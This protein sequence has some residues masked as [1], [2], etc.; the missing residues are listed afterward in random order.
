MPPG[1][2]RTGDGTV[3]ERNIMERLIIVGAGALGRE[4]LGLARDCRAKKPAFE[5]GG[6]IDPNPNALDGFG[7]AV[8]IIGAECRPEPGD[9][10]VV[11]VGDP[12]IRAR[13]AADVADRGGRLISLIHP[14]AYMAPSATVGDG[15][16]VAAF[17]F[18]AEN[19]R[20]GR[21]VFLNTYASVGHDADIGE[22]AVFSPYAVV[23]G[24]TVVE[25]DA[26][27]G[28]HAVLAQGCRLGEGARL[29]AGSVSYRNVPPG[30]LALGNPARRRK[31]PTP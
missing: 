24:D 13:L 20:V 18:I 11:A 14:L 3:R 28:T 2:H 7:V 21:N 6:F 4:I 30:Y 23:N 10:F 27:L 29:A 19:A 16:V 22:N 25:R 31:I 17:C 26:F 15:A 9:R 12:A 5:I 8:P 1:P